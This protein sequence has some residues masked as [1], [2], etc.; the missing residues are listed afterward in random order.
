VELYYEA[1]LGLMFRADTHF[2]RKD[3]LQTTANELRP[4]NTEFS[5]DN[6]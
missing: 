1:G 5:V 2:A 4:L 6:S 3:M